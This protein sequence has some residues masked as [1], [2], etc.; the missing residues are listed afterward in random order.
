MKRGLNIGA[1]MSNLTPEE[2]QPPPQRL[3]SILSLMVV[4]FAIKGGQIYLHC[5]LLRHMLHK[6]CFTLHVMHHLF[7]WNDKI[8]KIQIHSSPNLQHYCFN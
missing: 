1:V 4:V 8:Y 2:R 3:V 5:G 7:V 6:K